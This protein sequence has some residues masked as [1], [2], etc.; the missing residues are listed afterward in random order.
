[1]VF[2]RICQN[3]IDFEPFFSPKLS[4]Q[5]SSEQHFTLKITGDSEG[6]IQQTLKTLARF[7]I[8]RDVYVGIFLSHSQTPCTG[9]ATAQQSGRSWN[10]DQC[11][12]TL[13]Q[14]C[15]AGRDLLEWFAYL[16]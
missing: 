9:H 11:L 6:P 1:M 10:T 5:K 13:S 2:A 14:D 15:G 12:V 4:Y 8:R 7:R 3:S 16:A